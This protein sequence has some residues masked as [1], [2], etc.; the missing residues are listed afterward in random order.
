[1]QW[2][3]KGVKNGEVTQKEQSVLKWKILLMLVRI[4][5]VSQVFVSVYGQISEKS[6]EM[7]VFELN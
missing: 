6:T 2:R 7:K 1:M 3:I 4:N 5:A